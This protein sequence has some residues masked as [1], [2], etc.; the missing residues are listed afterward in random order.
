MVFIVLSI[1]V[2]VCCV[3]LVLYYSNHFI[4]YRNKYQIK[5]NFYNGSDFALSFFDS[6][7]I[8]W[9]LYRSR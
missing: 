8:T 7:K 1:A 6:W 4:V 2:I 5:T 3:P 9:E